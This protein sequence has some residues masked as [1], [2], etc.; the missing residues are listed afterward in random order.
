MLQKTKDLAKHME[1]LASST[2]IGVD[3]C[4][5][6]DWLISQAEEV[7][8]LKEQLKVAEEALEHIAEP[9][10]DMCTFFGDYN[11]VEEAVEALC[12]YAV[13]T[14]KKIRGQHG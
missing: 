3:D 6:V 9:I 4:D 1:G 12:V 13:Q 11:S 14:L 7:T 10:D 2:N 5:T 8:Q